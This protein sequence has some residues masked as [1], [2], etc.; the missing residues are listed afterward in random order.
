MKTKGSRTNMGKASAIAETAA[1]F[2]R[3]QNSATPADLQ[4]Q[5]RN[6]HFA[7]AVIER[8]RWIG[9]DPYA[10]AFFNCLSA[11]FPKGEAFFIEALKKFRDRTPPKLQGEIRSFIQQEAT[12]SR[13]HHFFNQH[14]AS[15]DRDISRLEQSISNVVSYVRAQPE[16]MHLVATMCIEHITAILAAEVIANPRHFENADG[17]QRKLWLWHASEEIE[18]KG[19][20]FDTWLHMSRDWSPLKR[21]YVRS[22][23]MAKISLGFTIN[24]TKGVLDLLRQDGITGPRAW[25]GL[26]RYA[27]VG[28]APLRRTFLPW[29]KFFKPG[30]HPW[31]IDDRH[32]IQLAESEYEAAVMDVATAPVE[33]SGPD[34]KPVDEGFR[35]VA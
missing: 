6:R 14:L 25:F 24:R 18:H 16:I 20:A 31:N 21:W 2:D 17:E 28:P 35:K 15:C 9:G 11:I 22:S 7:S 5:C 27:L 30:F 33:I 23:F 29:L 26:V 4:L 13:E 19:V 3:P 32:L 1:A 34:A 12:H 10:S 8:R